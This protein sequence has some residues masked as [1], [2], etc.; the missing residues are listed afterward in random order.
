VTSGAWVTLLVDL[1]LE[2]GSAFRSS[3]Y[4]AVVSRRQQH[5]LETGSV[6]AYPDTRFC[7]GSW[8]LDVQP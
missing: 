5:W 2:Q 4:V 3:R 8:V 7:L 1:A 6:P